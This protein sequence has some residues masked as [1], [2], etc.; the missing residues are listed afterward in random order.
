MKRKISI[1]K[2]SAASEK[3]QPDFGDENASR[4]EPFLVPENYFDELPQRIMERISSDT[5]TKLENPLPSALLRRVWMTLA[6]A[7]AIAVVF[8]MVRPENTDPAKKSPIVNLTP[9]VVIPDVYD[10]TYADEALLLEENEITDKD[11]TSIDYETI[12]IALTGSDTTS[13]TTEEIIQY[14]LD[15]NCDTDLLAGL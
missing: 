11:I 15:D 7:A 10:Q 8:M 3:Q 12:G 9:A 5:Q 14:L 1:S 13:V 4:T 6:A 2:H